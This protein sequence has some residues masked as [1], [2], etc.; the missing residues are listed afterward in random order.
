MSDLTVS[1]RIRWYQLGRSTNI[2]SRR[3]ALGQSRSPHRRWGKDEVTLA[4]TCELAHKRVASYWHCLPEYEQARKALWTA[5]NPH[6]GKRRIDEAFPPDLRESKDEQQMFI[7]FKCGSTWQLIGS[8]RF[9]STVG[10][11]PAGIV[12]SEWALANPSAWAY[13]RPMLE[14][15]NGWGAFITS[16]RGRNHAKAMYDMACQSKRWF[17]EISTIHD[18]RALTSDALD[19][20]PERI[21]RPLRRG[22]GPG[23]IRAGV[24]VFV[25]TPR[26]SE[27]SMPGR[28]SRFDPRAGVREFDPVDGPVHRAWDIGGQGTTLRSGGSR[29]S[30]TSRTSWTA[31]RTTGQGSITT[32][33][34]A[35]TVAGNPATTSCRTTPKCLSGAGERDAARSHDRQR[36]AA[37]AGPKCL[38]T[39]RDQ[40]GAHHAADRGVSSPL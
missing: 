2:S 18:T 3:R 1:R 6:T 24:S 13:H 40:R 14:E 23:P 33:R 7:R 27:R 8:D 12:Y 29:S 17:A 25:S 19:E 37:S 34:S 5:V 36:A 15:N 35:A 26:S 31:T 11:G 9:D 21:R 16:P 22:C 32:H 38:E 10:A 20:A 4:A 30:T 39:R 28:W